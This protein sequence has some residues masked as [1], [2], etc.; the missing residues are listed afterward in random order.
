MSDAADMTWEDVGKSTDWMLLHLM[1]PV[2][3]EEAWAWVPPTAEHPQYAMWKAKLEEEY[4]L[5]EAW[6]RERK[7]MFSIPQVINDPEGTYGDY[8][9]AF[10]R[11]LAEER[12]RLER[13]WWKFWLWGGK[14][15]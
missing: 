10:D 15:T 13:P 14:R 11:K 2:T 7:A 6:L 3:G 9:A 5:T 4:K 12:A 1:D 8:Q